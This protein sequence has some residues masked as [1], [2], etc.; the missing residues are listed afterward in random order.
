MGQ[1]EK[2]YSLVERTLDLAPV[3]PDGLQRLLGRSGEFSEQLRELIVR[4]AAKPPDFS[5]ARDILGDDFNSPE[6]ISAAC[7]QNS[8]I[9]VAS[10]RKSTLAP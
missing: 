6:D 10:A 8:D 5:L 9:D 7:G 3:S 4:L 2:F 1:R